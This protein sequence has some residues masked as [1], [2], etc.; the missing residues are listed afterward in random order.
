MYNAGVSKVFKDRQVLV[1]TGFK[2]TG[3]DFMV[4]QL[5][6]KL[7]PFRKVIRLSF[8]DELRRITNHIFP[9]VPLSPGNVEK[10]TPVE[11]EKNIGNLSPRQIWKLVADDN[12]GICSVQEDVLVDHFMMNQLS[13]ESLSDP[14]AL[15]VITDLRKI[16][17]NVFV[18]KCGFKKLRIVNPEYHRPLVEDN[19][20][21][22]IP[23]FKVD[24]ELLNMRDDSSI[25]EMFVV[26][27]K[28]FPNLAGELL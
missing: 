23:S 3:K 15:Y 12:T 24:H 2:Q 18:D 9:W 4:E 7:S 26:V 27:S 20:E 1:I 28:M 22:Y 16:C 13:E 10:E 11:T 25:K 6:E 14:D 5:R 17:E 19:V 8:S 21:R